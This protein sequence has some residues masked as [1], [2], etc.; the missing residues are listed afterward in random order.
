MIY[1]NSKN[2]LLSQWYTKTAKKSNGEWEMDKERI[3]AEWAN[4][5][6]PLSATAFSKQDIQLKLGLQ[7]HKYGI[8][9]QIL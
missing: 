8:K 3:A 1:L 9:Q 4:P 6:T 2:Q 5:I 7:L